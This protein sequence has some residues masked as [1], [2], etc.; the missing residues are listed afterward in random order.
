M[1]VSQELNAPELAKSMQFLIRARERAAANDLAKALLFYQAA[2]ST[3]RLN[4]VA[5]SEFLDF[6][7]IRRDYSNARKV[8]DA[9]PELV[10]QGAEKIR[11]SHGVLLIEEG[12][13]AE[14]L[15]VLLALESAS[16]LPRGILYNNIGTCYMRQE[17]YPDAL[18]YY[19]KARINGFEEFRLYT[20]LGVLYGNT[21]RHRE[22]EEAF[23]L[24]VKKY[25]ENKELAYEFAMFLL[26]TGSYAQGF[27][28]YS[29]RWGTPSFPG[30]KPHASL[31]EWTPGGNARRLLVIA[32]Q[33]IGDQ[34]VFSALLPYWRDKVDSLTFACDARLFPL[35][36]RAMPWV[37]C[38]DIGDPK[39]LQDVSGFDACLHAGDLGR[40]A[41]EMIGHWQAFLP[42]DED[43]VQRLRQRY[44]AL[45]P[46]KKLV[47]F[48]W[49]SKREGF[50]DKKTIGLEYWHDVLKTPGVQ[51]INFQYGDV[52]A[53]V[54]RVRREFG[55]EIYCD[56]EID[57]FSDLDKL[58][59][60]ARAVDLVITGS[61]SN[62]HLAAAA[63]A[64]VWLLAPAGAGGLWY[65]GVEGESTDW[66]PGVCVL[67]PPQ[68]GDWP[69][70]MTLVTKKLKNYL[71]E[72]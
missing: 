10:Y 16:K 20:N 51:F 2:V 25:P 24:G 32:E 15:E 70:L 11:L 31:P 50:G 64:A 9:I 13:Y 63:G 7:I 55:V 36:N 26:R 62:A 66:Y 60:Q 43:H 65:W 41:H 44:Q 61:N 27:S 38:V 45:F 49:R 40:Y 69:S 68:V 34:V 42:A 53:D 54:D 22:A 67:R 23:R 3:C 12:K 21:G 47:A 37:N 57:S 28:L 19:E 4:A 72:S 39:V 52:S 5:F 46:G 14:A 6:L 48:A 30:T 29:Q 59:A 35:L 8:V 18:R 17:H 56:P 33:G 58:A 71:G 1:P